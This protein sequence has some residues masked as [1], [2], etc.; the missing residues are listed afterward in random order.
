MKRVVLIA[1]IVC[2]LGCGPVAAREVLIPKPGI[3]PINQSCRTSQDSSGSGMASW[4]GF[5]LHGHRTADGGHFDMLALTAAHRTFPFGTRV[6]V[7]NKRNGKTVIVKINDRG[8]Y[9]QARVI[10]V[11][12]EA[13]RKL[14]FVANGT[15]PVEIRKCLSKTAYEWEQKQDGKVQS[16]SKKAVN[17]KD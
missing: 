13:A 4:Y 6:Q 2:A 10:D 12:K 1:G 3:K 11:S 17:I 14:G 5:E 16:R 9:A 7:K 15:A 8:P